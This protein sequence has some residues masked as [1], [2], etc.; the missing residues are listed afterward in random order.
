[1]ETYNDST[2]YAQPEQPTFEATAENSAAQDNVKNSEKNSNVGYV[3]GGAG[4]G[5]AVGAIAAWILSSGEGEA[6][7]VVEVTDTQ[8]E[9]AEPVHVV[10]HTQV[11]HHD[12]KPTNDNDYVNQDEGR[13]V[14]LPNG[15]VVY[16]HDYLADDGQMHVQLDVNLDGQY[17]VEYLRDHPEEGL[18]YLS[19]AEH[20]EWNEET[21]HFVQV[22]DVP[23][24]ANIA[25]L[26]A[27]NTDVPDASNEGTILAAQEVTGEITDTDGIMVA[28][29]ELP[30]G[31]ENDTLV[32]ENVSV[33][34]NDELVI[35]G[36]ND[37]VVAENTG[38]DTDTPQYD[39]VLPEYDPANDVVDNG[40]SDP[41]P[42]VADVPSDDGMNDFVNDA[43]VDMLA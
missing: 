39:E 6:Q 14:R 19:G 25:P 9:P 11:V 22:H 2:M 8:A 10:R 16:R 42:Y 43:N 27:L 26:T 5:L 1:M 18:T 38:T 23:E 29:D 28:H 36:G 12:A 34:G 30:Q 35:G 4:A 17:D 32:A 15:D 24:N 41:E 37:V 33:E 21:G 13:F 3:A 20:V 31:N 7:P 40:G